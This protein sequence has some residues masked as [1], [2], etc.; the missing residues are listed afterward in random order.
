[1]IL[2]LLL[3]GQLLYPIMN[4]KGNTTHYVFLSDITVLVN[5]TVQIRKQKKL[6]DA[7]NTLSITYIDFA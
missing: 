7:K 1:M 4:Q 2:R 5:H 6:I 3:R